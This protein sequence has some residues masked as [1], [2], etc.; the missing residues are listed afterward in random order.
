MEGDEG[1]LKN[2]TSECIICQKIKWQRPA[3]WEDLFD[4]HLYIVTPLQELSMKTTSECV[5]SS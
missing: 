1:D 4:H 3:D 5:I 2:D